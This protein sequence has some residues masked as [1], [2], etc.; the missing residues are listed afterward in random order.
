M[1]D[2]DELDPFLEGIAL[3]LKRPVQIDPAFDA[4]VMAALEPDVIPMP[5]T[6]TREVSRP[7]LLR[8]RTFQ[9][10][11]LSG[12]AAAAALT[13][14]AAMGMWK[15]RHPGD[16]VTVAPGSPAL[17]LTPVANT[18]A[19]APNAL[20]PV[21]FMI[22]A[23]DARSVALVGDFNGWDPAQTP[24]TKYSERDGV[25]TAHVALP[26]GQYQYQYLVDGER[27]ILDPVAPQSAKSEFGDANSVVT[28]SPAGV[29]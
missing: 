27:R 23:P 3:E 12:L 26:A 2:Q 14:I 1:T 10:T 16:A 7:W 4:R 21:T 19:P 22:T 29:R 25:W 24:L 15:V 6:R 28:V 18:G 20:M 8:P 13:G 11:P 5:G 9:L 17:E